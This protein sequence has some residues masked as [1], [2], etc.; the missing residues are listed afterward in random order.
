MFPHFR[1]VAAASAKECTAGNWENRHEQKRFTFRTV[2]S[3]CRSIPQAAYYQTPE[4]RAHHI[5]P[6]A[7]EKGGSAA[8][9]PVMAPA[10][11]PGRSRRGAGS[12]PWS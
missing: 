9:Y 4:F 2:E 10:E 11:L 7:V 8:V 3:P 6:G 1:F 12:A 5:P